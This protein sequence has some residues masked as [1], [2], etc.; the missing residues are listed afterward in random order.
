MIEGRGGVDFLGGDDGVDTVSYESAAAPVTVDLALTDPQVTGGAGAD[1]FFEPFENLIGGAGADSLRGTVGPNVIEGRAGP[2]RILALEGDDTVL[3]RDG[4]PDTVDCGPG[5][6]RAE[7]DPGGIDVTTA[8]ESVTVGVAPGLP[9]AAGAGGSGSRAP[10]GRR[11][12]EG[13]EEPEAR[14]RRPHPAAGLPGAVLR[15]ARHRL[16]AAP[17]ARRHA[18]AHDHA[19]PRAG[20]DRRR[21]VDGCCG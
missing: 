20:A 18:E 4:S 12:P 15:R 6:D 5:N 1:E 8:C 17:A 11:Q 10:P 2:D 3:V 14:A 9:G 16:D 13:A 19:A 7:V 21:E